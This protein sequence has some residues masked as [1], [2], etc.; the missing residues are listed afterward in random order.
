MSTGDAW[1]NAPQPPPFNAGPPA[2]QGSFIAFGPLAI[3]AIVFAL[4]NI[5]GAATQTIGIGLV[6]RENPDMALSLAA[7]GSVWCGC[8]M[9]LDLLTGLTYA[10]LY[11]R[12]QP[13]DLARGAAGGAISGAVSR[14]ISSPINGLVGILVTPLIYGADFAESGAM[15]A[16]GIIGIVSSTCIWLFGGAALGAIGGLLG[17]VFFGKK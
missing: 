7:V 2:A 15:V 4:I 9:L 17:G 11:K 5:I 1:G 3:A 14:V 12:S 8:A 6:I 16:G 13:V 10:F